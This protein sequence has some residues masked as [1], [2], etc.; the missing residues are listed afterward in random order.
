MTTSK[1]KGRFFYRTNRFESIR[2]TN[3]IESIRIV[4]WNA[5]SFSP[6]ADPH[7]FTV[8]QTRMKGAFISHRG[9]EGLRL[10]TMSGRLTMASRLLHN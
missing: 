4:N 9:I 8:P 2:I 1:S 10:A 6:N 3:R 7:H 5:L